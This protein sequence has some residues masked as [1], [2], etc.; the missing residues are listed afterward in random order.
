MMTLR[1]QSVLG[2][3]HRRSSDAHY[4]LG[5]GQKERK[6]VKETHVRVLLETATPRERASLGLESEK[7][8]SETQGWLA[9]EMIERHPKGLNSRRE[10][11]LTEINPRRDQWRARGR[12]HARDRRDGEPHGEIRETEGILGFLRK[13]EAFVSFTR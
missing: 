4:E 3:R 5:T 11:G 7:A 9:C 2:G 1:Q 13:I 8:K 12:T 6:S 10:Q